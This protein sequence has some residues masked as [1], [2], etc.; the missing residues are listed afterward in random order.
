MGTYRFEKGWFLTGLL[1]TGVGNF[2]VCLLAAAIYG[3]ITGQKNQ[4]V[5]CAL[6]KDFRCCR[7][8][9]ENNALFEL[10]GRNNKADFFFYRCVLHNRVSTAADEATIFVLLIGC[11]GKAITVSVSGLILGIW[12]HAT[13]CFPQLP[14]TGKLCGVFF[15]GS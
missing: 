3:K 4:L 13:L 12:K 2:Y 7:A 1:A 8:V 14:D 9:G 5:G 10:S 15:V 6:E 11:F